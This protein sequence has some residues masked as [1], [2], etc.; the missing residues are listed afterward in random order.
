M[1]SRNLQDLTPE[2]ADK[3]RKAEEKC[4]ARGVDLLIY[5]T[6]RTPQEQARLYRQGRATWKIKRKQKKLR[7][8][9]YGFLADILE[10]VGAQTGKKVTNAAPGESWH[11]FGQAFDAG[12]VVNGAI[13]WSYQNNKKSWNIYG[14][15]AEKL[16]L[17]WGGSWKSF[18]DYPHCQLIS[19][20]NPTDYY[21]P[22][23][24]EN[25]LR[26]MNLI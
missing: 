24:M 15:I 11:N 7:R 5:C 16:G 6:L 12:P 4:K 19:G 21:T 17:N 20:G 8:E 14:N 25:K 26:K 18:K 22:E 2:L 13:Q 9:G 23:K 3:A 1:A 10:K